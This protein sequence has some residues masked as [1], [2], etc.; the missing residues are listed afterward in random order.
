MDKDIPGV[1]YITGT[2]TAAYGGAVAGSFGYDL[3]SGQLTMGGAVGASSPNVSFSIVGWT[4]PSPPGQAF[5]FAGSAG[6]FN[7]QAQFDAKNVAQ[8]NWTPQPNLGFTL[9]EKVAAGGLGS[10][11]GMY[12][13]SVAVGTG[14]I[15]Y[16][17]SWG[18]ISRD[19]SA[20]PSIFSLEFWN[21]S[22]N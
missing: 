17:S 3:N 18:S 9:F 8:G 15:L 11:S 4:E 16:D 22:R 1:N 13:K 6:P 21:F 12:E 14:S 19:F 10:V 7:Y 2:I 5:T 20:T